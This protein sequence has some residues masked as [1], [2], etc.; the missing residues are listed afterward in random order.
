M[1]SACLL[2][3]SIM[4]YWPEREGSLEKVKKSNLNDKVITCNTSCG[5]NIVW[6]SLNA[7]EM[8]ANYKYTLINCMR[9]T[10]GKLCQG[11]FEKLTKI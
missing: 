6:L 2:L 4:C 5:Y 8:L 11:T 3:N 7:G 9:G 1:V 10:D